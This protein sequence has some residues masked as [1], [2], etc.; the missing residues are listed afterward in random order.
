MGIEGLNTARWVLMD[1]GDVIV[2]I[3]EEESR[4]YY[5]LERFW[6]DAPRIS[7]EKEKILVGKGG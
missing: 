1:Y 3:F 2:H 4:A 5:G 7:Y 6:L